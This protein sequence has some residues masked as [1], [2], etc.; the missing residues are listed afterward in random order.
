M[1]EKQENGSGLGI[2]GYDS[3]EFVVADVE[4]SRRFYT[5]MMDVPEVARLDER[6]AAERGEDAL[7][8]TPARPAA[9]AS[10]PAN[11]DR[12]RTV[13]SEGIP[14]GVRVVS[15]RVRDLGA[16]REVLA[17]RGA[18]FCTEVVER[19]D[20]QGRAL[21]PPRHRHPAGRGALP[22]SSNGRLMPCRPAFHPWR[23]ARRG[24]RTASR[25]SITS[26]RTSSP[27]SPTSPGCATS[28]A[29]PSTGEFT[30]TP[31]TSPRNRAA[32]ASPQLSCGTPTPESSSPTT[33]R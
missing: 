25:S 27:S 26:P 9:C 7:L 31:P 5:E 15:F 2:I 11:A 3:Y 13:G 12:L 16:T 20:G 32:R 1:T 10:P 29:L 28:W 8:F 4:R 14:D 18:A 21:P 24:T 23:Q 17:E 6:A 33:S 19:V 22:L 30:F